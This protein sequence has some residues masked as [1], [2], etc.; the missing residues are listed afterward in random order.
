MYN[1]F[2]FSRL[3]HARIW[4]EVAE[5]GKFPR[6]MKRRDD[7]IKDVETKDWIF[8]EAVRSFQLSYH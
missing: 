1:K 7:I 5:R 6:W 4:S 3:R 2:I 8:R